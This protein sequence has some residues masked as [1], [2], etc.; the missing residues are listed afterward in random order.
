MKRRQDVRTEK[1][2]ESG[3]VRRRAVTKRDPICKISHIQAACIREIV[4]IVQ[5]SCRYKQPAGARSHSPT[6]LADT[7]SLDARDYTYRRTILRTW[8]A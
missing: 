2:A 6:Y 1:G 4:H 7:G 8:A 5:Q 3:W